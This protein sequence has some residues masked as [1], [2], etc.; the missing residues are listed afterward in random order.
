MGNLSRHIT[1]E[2]ALFQNHL[3]IGDYSIV[4]EATKCSLILTICTITFN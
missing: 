2:D 4:W 3:I 1:K